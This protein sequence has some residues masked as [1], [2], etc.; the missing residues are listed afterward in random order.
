MSAMFTLLLR[1]YPRSFR[2][3]YGGEMRAIFA[4]RWCGSTAVRARGRLCL[5]AVADV[6]RNAPALHWDI[7][8]QDVAFA[9]LSRLLRVAVVQ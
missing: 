4:H 5:E 9:R 8:R 2:D 1:L 6:A 3:E 7:L